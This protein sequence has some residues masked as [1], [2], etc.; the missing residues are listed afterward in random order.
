MILQRENN[1]NAQPILNLQQQLLSEEVRRSADRIAELRA[2]GFIEYCSSGRIYR[3]A[4]GDTFAHGPQKNW[5]IVDFEARPLADEVVLATYRLLKHDGP[6]EAM[7]VSLRSSIWKVEDGKW[8]MIFH[9][10]TPGRS[11]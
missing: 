11:E 1:M 9:Q 8:K 4:R 6:N 5:E 7:R 2:K 3:Y 10:G